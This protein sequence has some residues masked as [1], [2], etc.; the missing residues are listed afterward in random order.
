MFSPIYV[1]KGG[2]YFRLL[3]SPK[4][5]LLSVTSLM[6]LAAVALHLASKAIV[7]YM[8]LKPIL[9]NKKF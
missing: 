3:P 5:K 6:L 2:H 9:Q 8:I 1:Q 4:Q 7:K